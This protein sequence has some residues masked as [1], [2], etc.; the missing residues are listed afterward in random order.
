[1]Q[2]TISFEELSDLDNEAL[3][4]LTNEQ[5]SK[6]EMKDI[7][8]LDIDKIR[9]LFENLTHVRFVLMLNFQTKF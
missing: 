6:F 4:L 8:K 9:I 3:K 7:S 5:L 1:M 2:L